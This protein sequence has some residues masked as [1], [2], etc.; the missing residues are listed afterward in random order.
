MIDHHRRI[1][2]LDSNVLAS[3]TLTDVF[4]QL[5]V[6]DVFIAKWTMDIHREWIS[7]VRKFRPSLDPQRLER[8]RRQMDAKTREALITGYESRIDD[9]TLPDM[10]DRHVLAAAIH[11]RCELIVTR[12]LKDFPATALSTHGIKAIHPDAFLTDLLRRNTLM[13]CEALR[14]VRIRAMNPPI[15]VEDFLTRLLDE[16]LI[17]TARELK[18]ESRL[19]L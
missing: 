13:F 9:L 16:G 2:L 8:R 12:N 5:A 10:N 14:K 19:L 15:D 18:F 11:G 3:I 17:Q 6:D 7:A 1:A 4:V